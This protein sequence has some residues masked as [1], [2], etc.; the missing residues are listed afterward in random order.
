MQ[1]LGQYLP[2][3]EGSLRRDRDVLYQ[4]RW[5]NPFVQ[6]VQLRSVY[7]NVCKF[8]PQNTEINSNNSKNRVAEGAGG[9]S[10]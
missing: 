2:R 1:K 3:G 6:N 7:F 4:D 5:R 8:Y 9:R 10:S